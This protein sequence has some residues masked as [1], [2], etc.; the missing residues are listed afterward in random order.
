VE[1]ENAEKAFYG[2]SCESSLASS[3]GARV[4]RADQDGTVPPR[5]AGRGRG[6]VKSPRRRHLRSIS[7]LHHAVPPT[8][9][10]EFPLC[11]LGE[12]LTRSTRSTLHAVLRSPIEETKEGVVQTS[13]QDGGG[14]RFSDCA[15]PAT[16]ILYEICTHAAAPGGREE[17]ARRERQN[18]TSP[19]QS[20]LS[21][22]K[23]N[24]FTFCL[25]CILAWLA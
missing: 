24:I 16:R 11:A 20:P 14:V 25:R 12:A 21:C 4:D 18:W 9:R 3:L 23:L 7:K 10:P 22:S 19:L 15:V 17:I 8:C 6:S 1:V 5:S 13:R 2:R